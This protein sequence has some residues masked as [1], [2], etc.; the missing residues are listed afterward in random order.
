MLNIAERTNHISNSEA[1]TNQMK[2]RSCQM[3]TKTVLLSI[4]LL[5]LHLNSFSLFFL[6]LCLVAAFFSIIFQIATDPP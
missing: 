5:F 4:F 2:R 1:Y 3:R 6:L